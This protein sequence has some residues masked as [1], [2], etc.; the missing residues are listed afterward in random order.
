M[1]GVG[2][3]SLGYGFAAFRFLGAG[4]FVI[5]L[6]LYGRVRFRPRRLVSGFFGRKTITS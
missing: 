6:V 3:S 1:W 2:C 5:A 4:V